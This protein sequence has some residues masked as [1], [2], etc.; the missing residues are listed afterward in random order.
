[1]SWMIEFHKSLEVLN[2]NSCLKDEVNK[3]HCHSNK[4]SAGCL[5]TVRNMLARAAPKIP[6]GVHDQD[7]NRCIDSLKLKVLN[8]LL[9]RINSCMTFADLRGRIRLK[10]ARSPSWS[11]R[12]SAC[13]RVAASVQRFPPDRF[14][15]ASAYARLGP[16]RTLQFCNSQRMFWNALRDYV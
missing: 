6:V 7:P 12:S 1:M 5:E 15:G 9:Q 4:W 3:P 11:A 8:A 10:W 13:M 14:T 2:W 16:H